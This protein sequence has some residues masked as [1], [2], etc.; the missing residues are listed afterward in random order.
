MNLVCLMMLIVFGDRLALI[1]FSETL[2]L[3]SF[4]IFILGLIPLWVG[5]WELYQNKMATRELLWQYKNQA[6]HFQQASKK[7]ESDLSI[8][9]MQN[10]IAELGERS[11]FETYQWTIHRYHRESEPPPTL[12]GNTGIAMFQ[13]RVGAGRAKRTR[14]VHPE[15]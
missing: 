10:I 7:M 11:L 8:E 15:K 5:I 13:G 6:E 14:A 9:A 12:F 4:L 1:I 2:T 3:K